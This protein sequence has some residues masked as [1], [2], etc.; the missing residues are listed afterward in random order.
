MFAYIDCMALYNI[1]RELLN[2][3]REI[4]KIAENKLRSFPEGALRVK[5]FKNGY[6]YYNRKS[7]GD[8][9]GIYLNKE[10]LDTI[11]DLE[12]KSYYS[13]LEKA[14]IERESDLN[15][16]KEILEEMP[17]I[18]AVYFDIPQ[19][20]RHLIKPFELRKPMSEEDIAK[21]NAINRRKNPAVPTKYYV[22]ENGEKVRSKSEV[23]IA[24]KLKAA[25]VPYHYESFLNLKD[26]L[27]FQKYV[28]APDFKVL[29]KTDRKEY[30][31]E[32]FGM[33]GNSEYCAAALFKIE[34]YAEFGFYPGENLI[35]T[36]ESSEHGLNTGY[37]DLM[38]E[39]YLL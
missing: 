11:R 38:I 19:E 17:S 25:G 23:I 31:W 2:E 30:Y 15:K 27:C 34:K 7:L 4:K 16:I 6:K 21:W 20:R 9:N 26:E 36:T 18:E 3:T 29:S 28:W 35:I 24:N 8:T 13:L 33:M 32:H 10:N 12:D 5:R 39:K 1:V 22:T 37:I 14:A